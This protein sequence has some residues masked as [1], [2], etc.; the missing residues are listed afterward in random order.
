MM[1]SASFLLAAASRPM[2]PTAGNLGER[3]DVSTTTTV[4][5]VSVGG[6]TTSSQAR[7]S[8]MMFQLVFLI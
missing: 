3:N 6:P 1:P 2:R 4:V 7:N 8:G 5:R